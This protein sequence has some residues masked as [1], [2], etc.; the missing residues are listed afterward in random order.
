MSRKRGASC[1]R[2]YNKVP[3]KLPLKPEPG[4]ESRTAHGPFQPELNVH[5]GEVCFEWSC[6]KH[7]N[8][9]WIGLWLSWDTGKGPARG[10]PGGIMQSDRD[11]GGRGSL[12]SS[13]LSPAAPSNYVLFLRFR[14]IRIF[15]NRPPIK[16][17]VCWCTHRIR[18]KKLI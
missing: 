9:A 15:I 17:H 16:R 7:V 3:E 8:N 4:A 6:R 14:V 18:H 5:E 2:C 1:T 13:L 10:K 12:P 11:M